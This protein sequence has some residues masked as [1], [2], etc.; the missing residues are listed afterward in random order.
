M[1][2]NKLLAGRRLTLWIKEMG[3]E[4]DDSQAIFI[5]GPPALMACVARKSRLHNFSLWNNPGR[6]STGL[7]ADSSRRGTYRA[8]VRPGSRAMWIIMYIAMMASLRAMGL[9]PGLVPVR[10]DE[11]RPP[12]GEM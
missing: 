11:D 4:F 12:F 1:Q 3:R 9:A 10:T 7:N 6:N 5:G 8:W 2:E